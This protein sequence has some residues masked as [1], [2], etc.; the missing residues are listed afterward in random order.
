MEVV[1]I[2]Q[3]KEKGRSR[4]RAAGWSDWYGQAPV[5]RGLREAKGGRGRVRAQQDKGLEERVPCDW[6]VGG[7][8][9]A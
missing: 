4:D 9:R 2:L 3:M 8:V 1:T 6:R 5:S 7:V